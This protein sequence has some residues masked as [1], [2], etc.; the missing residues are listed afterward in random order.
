MKLSKLELKWTERRGGGEH[1]QTRRRFLDFVIDGESLYEKLWKVGNP[2]VM[3]GDPGITF[4]GWSG[5]VVWEQPGVERLLGEAAPE[6]WAKQPSLYVCPECGDLDCGAITV[7]VEKLDDIVVWSAFAWEHPNYEEPDD[8]YYYPI[9]TVGPF[10]FEAS[11]LR[12]VLLNRP[13]CDP[14]IPGS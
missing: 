11:H 5:N 12:D 14:S 8:P 4:L 9:E 3:G 6:G 13:K 1:N 7:K 2:G 10:S